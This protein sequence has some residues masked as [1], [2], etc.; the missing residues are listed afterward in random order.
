MNLQQGLAHMSMQSQLESL[1]NTN[2]SLQNSHNMTISQQHSNGFSNAKRENSPPNM[3]NNNGIPGLNLGMNMTGMGSIF[4]PLP[5]VSMPMQ[6]SQL[7]TRK[8]ERSLPISQAQMQPK[9]D[10]EF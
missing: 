7:P 1:I 2:N 5:M 8:E 4:D 6:I 3:L 9:M 10:G